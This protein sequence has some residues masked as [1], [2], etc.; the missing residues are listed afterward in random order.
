MTRPSE[1]PLSLESCWGATF[2]F[3]SVRL[4]HSPFVVLSFKFYEE[5]MIL[6]ENERESLK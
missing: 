1:F 5:G 6:M 3:L 2:I 4:S